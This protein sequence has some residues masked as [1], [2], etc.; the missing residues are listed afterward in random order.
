MICSLPFLIIN[1]G[2][3]ASGII[4]TETNRFE[5]LAPVAGRVISSRL[6][7]NGQI[8]KGDVIL[9]ID[10]TT[11]S[12]ELDQIE[13]RL[14]ELEIFLKDLSTLIKGDVKTIKS[15]RYQIE[16]LQFE[17]R[18][19]QLLFEKNTYKKIFERQEKL[20]SQKVIA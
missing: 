16:Q 11:I 9:R 5:I 18:L 6:A 7:E 15:S 2:T 12:H 1:V 20:Y 3:N 8:R 13:S 4:D 10:N 14:I 19:E 17:T